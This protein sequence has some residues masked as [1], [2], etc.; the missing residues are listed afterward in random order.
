MQY[1]ETDVHCLHQAK[2]KWQ[3]MLLSTESFF[4]GISTVC[5][6]KWVDLLVSGAILGLYLFKI[7]N[8]IFKI[9]ELTGFIKI[10]RK[11]LAVYLNIWYELHL[12][13][14]WNG[15]T[16][17]LWMFFQSTIFILKKNFKKCKKNKR[18]KNK[19]RKKTKEITVN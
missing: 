7:S 6:N 4:P 2:I 12:F 1:Y 8:K 9:K 13:L 19:Q 17:C 16:I 14:T 18:R 15:Q 5:N 11:W 10:H 3:Q